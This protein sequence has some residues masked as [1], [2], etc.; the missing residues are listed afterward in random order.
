[1]NYRKP[2]KKDRVC[3]DVCEICGRAVETKSNPGRCPD[4][5]SCSWKKRA[6]EEDWKGRRA[7]YK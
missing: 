3:Y 2:E 4:C 5:G 1:M 7:R 6:I